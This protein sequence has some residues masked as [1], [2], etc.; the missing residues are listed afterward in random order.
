MYLIYG[1]PMVGAT[2]SRNALKLLAMMDYPKK[3]TEDANIAVEHFLATGEWK[4]RE[5]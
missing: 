1:T 3:I 4:V 2:T 5:G